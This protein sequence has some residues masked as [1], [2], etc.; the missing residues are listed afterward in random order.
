MKVL[1]KTIVSQNAGVCRLGYSSAHVEIA[2]P[3]HSRAV[4]VGYHAGVQNVSTFPAN[5]TCVVNLRTPRGHAPYRR[6]ESWVSNGDDAFVRYSCVQCGSTPS[7]A[8]FGIPRRVVFM[9]RH[10]Y[11]GRLPGIY[12]PHLKHT[13]GV[14]RLHD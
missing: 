11:A 7:V 12:N 13:C 1:Q 9:C 2:E 4:M 8:L 5:W 10:A 14:D 3:G 6:L